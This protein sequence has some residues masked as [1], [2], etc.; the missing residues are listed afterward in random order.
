MLENAA[1][2][3]SSSTVSCRA[4]IW[5]LTPLAS[6]FSRSASSPLPNPSSIPP[7]VHSALATCDRISNIPL[8]MS[9]ISRSIFAATASLPSTLN[10]L[11]RIYIES[12]TRGPLLPR[13]SFRM[14]MVVDTSCRATSLFPLAAS[15]RERSSRSELCL[16]YRDFSTCSLVRCC[17]S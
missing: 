14:E 15:M 8:P 13:M 5:P 16:G 2:S 12:A 3:F 10:M 17:S 6:R 4:S 7:S 1:S 11:A 9:T